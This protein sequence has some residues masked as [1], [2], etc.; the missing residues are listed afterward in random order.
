M[1]GRARCTDDVIRAYHRNRASL[2][3]VNFNA[4]SESN[5]EKASFRRL[6]P[7]SLCLVAVEGFYE[8]KKDGSK[9][10]PHYVYF[11]DGRPLLFADRYDSWENS[12]DPPQR[13][14]GLMPVFGT[15]S[16]AIDMDE[17][18]SPTIQET[19]VENPLK[20]KGKANDDYT[21]Q[22]EVATSLQL[23]A[24]QNAI[25]AEERNRRHEEQ[26]KQIQEA[27]DDKNIE[28]NTSNYTPMNRMPVILDA[29]KFIHQVWYPVKRAMGKVPFDG[30]E[31]I[32]EVT[33]FHVF[34]YVHDA[35]VLN[36]GGGLKRN[37]LYPD[38]YDTA[39]L[40]ILAASL[41]QTK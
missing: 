37:N 18:G 5:C 4:R 38:L 33:R 1:C 21:T 9:K 26:A 22:Q 25:D 28:R 13:R 10:H 3:T 27:M 32:D 29:K 30:P 24:E 14:V 15:T 34:S 8:W 20:E 11:K 35:Y 19:R 39:K 23:M 36:Y 17:N 12:E 7:K 16:S 41:N 31:C 2:R 6:A 40:E